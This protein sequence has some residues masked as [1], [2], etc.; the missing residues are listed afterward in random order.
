MTTLLDELMQI[1]AAL[2]DLTLFYRSG[3]A[4]LLRTPPPGHVLLTGMG[5]SYHAAAIG[6]FMLRQA[7]IDAVATEAADLLYA[8]PR[9]LKCFDKL[10]YISQSGGSGEIRPFLESLP[11]PLLLTALTN[12]PDSELARGAGRVLPLTAGEENWIASKT[13]INALATLWLQSRLWGGLSL[14]TALEELDRLA[15]DIERVQSGCTPVLEHMEAAFSNHPRLIFLGGGPHALT[16]R[17]AAMTLSEW[18]KLSSQWYSLGSFRHGFIETVDEG[19]AIYLFAPAG[20]TRNSALALA[21]EL[22]GYGAAT[23]F[24]E[25]GLLRSPQE[26]PASD[27]GPHELLSPILDILPVQL[28]AEAAARK[29]FAKPG[30]RYLS[31][32]VVNL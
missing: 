26:I 25:Y 28:Y 15:V 9:D 21:R 10:L 4:G 20:P 3:G 31:K 16:A 7:G 24:I 22:N 29:F 23:T 17:E 19:S 27:C 12:S 2:R 13:Y 30:F 18:P 14:P 5:A 11:D 8:F 6:A 32:V 1:P